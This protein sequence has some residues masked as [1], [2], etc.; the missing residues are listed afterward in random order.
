[1]IEEDSVN[2]A[3]C[4]F[5]GNPYWTM[6]LVELD[7]ES[8]RELLYHQESSMEERMSCKDR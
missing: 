8:D 4:L 6:R 3:M 2:A 7:R 1:M 5:S